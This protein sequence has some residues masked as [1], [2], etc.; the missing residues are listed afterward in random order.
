MEN[1]VEDK[2]RVARILSRD[3]F[4]DGRLLHVAFALNHGESY[5]SVNRMSV[6]S[7]SSDVKTF[8]ETHAKYIFGDNQDE[9]FRALLTVRDIRHID[10][11]Y[12][13]EKLDVAVEVEPRSAHTKSH[14][15]IFTRYHNKNVKTDGMLTISHSDEVASDVIL[16]KVQLSLL[17]QSIVENSKL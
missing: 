10:V 4:E 9:Y 6:S 5:L 7:F 15:G 3:W 1:Y 16:L 11:E 12:K 13:G 14:A 17:R 2:E 8:V